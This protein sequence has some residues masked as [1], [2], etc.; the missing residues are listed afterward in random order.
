MDN[1]FAAMLGMMPEVSIA[2]NR[3]TSDGNNQEEA[4]A[5]A[6]VKSLSNK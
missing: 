6:I 4:M 1:E 5:R 2:V 3:E